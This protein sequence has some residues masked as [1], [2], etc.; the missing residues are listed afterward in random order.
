MSLF[1][2]FNH[3]SLHQ[4]PFDDF[5]YTSYPQ[6]RHYYHRHHDY[7]D[8]C[9]GHDSFF[10][11]PRREQYR[12]KNLQMHQEREAQ[13]YHQHQLRI[14]KQKERQHR[15]LIQKQKR[16]AKALVTERLKLLAYV[17]S[18]KIIQRAYRQYKCSKINNAALIIA[19]AIKNF[20]VTRPAKFIREQLV[21][22]KSLYSEVDKSSAQFQKNGLEARTAKQKVQNRLKY[23]DDLVKLTLKADE[24]QTKGIDII[25]YRRKAFVKHT[26]SLLDKL[27]KTSESED[28]AETSASDMELDI[29]FEEP[30]GSISSSMDLDD[31]KLL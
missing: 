23:E 16:R 24:I 9:F 7:T 25:R 26:Q 1:F 5:I 18:A 29:F 28:E 22:L 21:Y 31:D 15:Q 11:L 13:L 19:R 6:R 27:D 8:D 4:H 10:H 20:I 3:R 14:Q 2:P 12:R 17:R 30:E